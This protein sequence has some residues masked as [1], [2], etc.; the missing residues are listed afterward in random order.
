VIERESGKEGA[1]WQ[2]PNLISY[3]VDAQQTFAARKT[4]S[5]DHHIVME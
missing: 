3:R 2:V 4:C 1:A 5:Q